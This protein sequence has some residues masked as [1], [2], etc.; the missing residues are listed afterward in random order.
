MYPVFLSG[1]LS[2][3]PLMASILGA[4]PPLAR[5]LVAGTGGRFVGRPGHFALRP[6]EG[7]QV[8]GLALTDATPDAMARLEF[9]TQAVGLGRQ[10]VLMTGENGPVQAVTHALGCTPD[11][12]PWDTELWLTGHAALAIETAAE[13][14]A[15][16]GQMPPAQVHARLGPITVRAHSRL[17][18]RDGQAPHTLRR[19]PERITV[20]A[21]RQPYANFFAVEEYD[22]S[23]RRFDHSM[24]PVITRAAF[25]SADA[26]TVLPYDPQRD[27]V[28][29]VEQM[30]TG[31][32]GRGDGNPWQ[33]EAIAG[34][35]DAG[36]TPEACA[37]REACEEAGLT[38]GALLSVANYYPSPGAKTEF[39]YS[40]VA[41]ADLPD[42]VA[43]V[44][45]VEDEAED[46]RGHLL[47]FDQA[48]ALVAS[49]EIQNAPLLLT[50]LWLQRERGS[51]RA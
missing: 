13:V 12:Q 10:A 3:A 9:Y 51:L 42:G 31:P 33:L 34:R 28:L 46:I 1:P 24:S 30:R 15:C 19:A 21:R 49:G 6:D 17:R 47:G 5:A 18:A 29:L 38:L 32:F 26:V 25:V 23:F 48:L 37:R 41:L 4:V 43:G 40:Y 27:R 45:G 36:E 35:I 14:M 2:H 11:A 44:F 20:Q 7:A 16:Y 8:G 39:I 22:L 50:L